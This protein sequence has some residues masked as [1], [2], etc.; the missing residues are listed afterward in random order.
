MQGLCFLFKAMPFQGASIHD[1][2]LF[3]PRKL[4][5]FL[6]LNRLLYHDKATVPFWTASG[7]AA[8]SSPK[9]ETQE[10]CRQKLHVIERFL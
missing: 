4:L 8:K 2:A 7:K 10:K 5:I 3:H 1:F 9:E 6:I